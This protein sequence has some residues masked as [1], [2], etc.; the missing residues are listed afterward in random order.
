MDL[1][2]TAAKNEINNEP[3]DF[4]KKFFTGKPNSIN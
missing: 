4:S 1:L 3:T 2:K